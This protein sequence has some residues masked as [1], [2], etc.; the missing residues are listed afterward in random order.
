[1]RYS[2][3]VAYYTSNSQYPIRASYFVDLPSWNATMAKEQLKKMIR[4][5][6]KIEILDHKP[7]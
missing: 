3:S 1:M 4:V 6:T 5:A 2:V 7:L